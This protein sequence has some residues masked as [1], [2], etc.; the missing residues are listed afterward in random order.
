MPQIGWFEILIIALAAAFFG[1][2]TAL[3]LDLTTF[4][5]ALVVFG[6]AEF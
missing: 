6:I 3:V 4:F 5:F 2:L 1:L